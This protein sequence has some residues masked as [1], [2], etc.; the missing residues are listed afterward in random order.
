MA[1]SMTRPMA[2]GKYKGKD[3]EDI[4]SSYLK[5]LLEQNWFNEVYYKD[6]IEPIEI[7]LRFRDKFNT[8]F[9]E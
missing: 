7:E 4:P 5:W 6:M 1:E 2:F 3:I 9:E 8:H